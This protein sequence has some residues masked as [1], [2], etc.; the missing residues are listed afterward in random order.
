MRVVTTVVF[1]LPAVADDVPVEGSP[2]SRRRDHRWPDEGPDSH[3]NGP[4]D[5]AR[6]QLRPRTETRS[7]GSREAETLES[8]NYRS[9]VGAA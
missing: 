8:N 1:G 2:R 4:R 3:K 7:E 5:G 6:N 9:L